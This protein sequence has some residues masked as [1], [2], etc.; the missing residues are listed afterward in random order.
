[1][2]IPQIMDDDAL[3]EVV[4]GQRVEK[5]MGFYECG[6]ATILTEYL[7]VFVRS[8]HLGRVRVETSFLIDPA[9]GQERRP[10]VAFVSYDRWPRGQRLPRGNAAPVVPD[11]AVEVVSP[12]NTAT[13]VQTKRHEY[14]RA[15]VRAVWVV[16]PDQFEVHVFTAPTSVRILA[17]ND[18]LDGGAVVPGFRLPVAA[19]FEDELAPGDG[20][21]AGA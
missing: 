2:T 18:E 21:S 9:R 12:S 4:D 10:D 6:I 11:L 16:F 8:H 13:E 7:A 15:G 17:R 14:F 1:M 3:F 20:D 5:V 19:L